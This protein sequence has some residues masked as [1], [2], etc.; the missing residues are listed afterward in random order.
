[1]QEDESSTCL[2]LHGRTGIALVALASSA[3][4]QSFLVP[5]YSGTPTLWGKYAINPY[6]RLSA[7][8]Q[9][10]LVDAY[11]D[12]FVALVSQIE[13]VFVG[14][15]LGLDLKLIWVN[16]YGASVVTKTQPISSVS[17]LQELPVQKSPDHNSSDPSKLSLPSTTMTP[18]H[19]SSTFSRNRAPDTTP[20]KNS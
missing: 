17:K 13:V 18:P 8:R 10:S 6:E 20:T 14:F 11:I 4:T 15:L 3:Y 9:D 1:M 7:L 19:P 12:A 5:A 2:G 16:S